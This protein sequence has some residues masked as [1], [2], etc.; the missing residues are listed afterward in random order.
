M[1]FLQLLKQDMRTLFL[2]MD[3]DA[4]NEISYTEFIASIR[5]EISPNRKT[6]IRTVFDVIDKD[7]DG[8]ISMTGEIHFTSI[9][10]YIH[11]YML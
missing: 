5:G 6:I 8:I 9:H 1:V 7:G 10:T 4:N 2:E 11:T 3:K